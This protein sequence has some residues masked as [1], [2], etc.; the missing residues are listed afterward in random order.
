MVKLASIKL[1]AKVL[2]L[3][4]WRNNMSIKKV[5][6]VALATVMAGVVTLSPITP[7][8]AAVV[9]PAPAAKVSFT[10]DDGLAS[11]LT[12]AKPT[13]AKYGLT[14]TNYVITDCVGKTTVPNTCRADQDESYMTWAQIKQLQTAGWEIASHTKT[15]PYLAS[16]DAGDG[17]PNVLTPAQVTTELTQSKAAFAAQGINVE[18]FSSPYGDYN[19]ATL[20]QV[21]KYYQNH[22]GFADTNNNVWPFNDYLLNNMQVQEGVTVAQVKAKIDD[23]IANKYWLVLTFHDVQAVPSTDP[24]DYEYATSKLDQI[25]AYV[26]SKQTAGTLQSVNVKNG[27]VKS[28][29]NMFANSSFDSGIAGGWT[30]DNAAIFKADSANNGSYNGVASGPTKSVAVAAGATNAHLYSPKVAVSNTQ[31]YMLK[32]FLNVTNRTAGELGYYID[33]YDAN[34]NWISGQ[35]KKA[36]NSVYVESMNFTYTPSSAN[37]KQASLQVYVTAGS[38]I[39]AFIDNFQMFPLSG[40]PPVVTPPTNLV[41]NGTFDAGLT[42]WTTNSPATIKADAA[43]NGSPANATNSVLL[44]AASANRHLFGPMVT[45]SAGKSYTLTSYLNVKAITSGEV[46]YYIDEYDTNGNWISGQYKTGV[47]TVK[48]GDVSFTYTPSSANVAKASMQVI[49]VGNSGI[50]AYLDDVRWFQN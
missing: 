35:W 32:S 30:T 49:V 13:L 42:G 23:A 10:F 6:G 18:S 39:K 45:L 47:S 37:V 24:N 16:S 31:T 40:T 9:A 2:H 48:A 27:I 50:T 20:A 33:E 22:R 46:G 43:N 36:E 28:D 38:G 4:P 44:T 17:Q 21:A 29:V 26:K 41:A 25:A 8:Y 3:L 7:A 34:G 14:G 15:H 11:A 5:F 12:Q 1:A 19:N